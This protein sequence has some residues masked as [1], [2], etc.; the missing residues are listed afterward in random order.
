V[1]GDLT[2]LGS[3]TWIG[4]ATA[5]IEI[6]DFRVLTDP[7]LRKRV[8]H[9]RRRGPAP[10]TGS[11]RP[12]LVLISHAHMDHLHV[13][14]L[15]LVDDDVPIIGPRGVGGLL[16]RAGFHRVI[17][18]EAGDRVEVGRAEVDVTPALHPTGRGPHSRIDPRPIGFIV[19][20]GGHRTYFAG[21]TDLFDDMA[22]F[23]RIDLAL[24]P[25][26]G[27]GSTIGEGHLDPERAIRASELIKPGLVVP[28][29][30]G[31]YAPED[32][33]REPAWLTLP[34]LEFDRLAARSDIAPSIVLPPGGATDLHLRPSNGAPT[35][36][37]A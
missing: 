5:L 15:K 11:L 22:G 1:T 4:H 12:D 14:S 8:A 23:E 17:E 32:L 31:T 6:G 2:A 3:L 33:R 24:L 16:R 21:D 30:W 36:D 19:E 7:L 26:W 9:L 13:P 20:V 34:A 35:T 18:V 27:W 25:I 10:A 29:H 28:V 37:G